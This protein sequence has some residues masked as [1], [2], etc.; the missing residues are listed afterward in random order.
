MEIKVK[1]INKLRCLKFIFIF[2]FIINACSSGVPTQTIQIVNTGMQKCSLTMEKYN[3]NGKLSDKYSIDES[4]EPQKEVFVQINEGIYMIS[5]WDAEG[6]LIKKFDKISVKLS[7]GKSSFNPIVIDAAFNKNYALVNLNYLYS[8][9]VF[10]EH[11]SK[12]VGTNSDNLEIIHFYNGEAPFFV[13]EKYR[14]SLTFVDIFTDKLPKETVYGNTVYGL[15]PV[16]SEIK[17]KKEINKYI[18]N[19]LEKKV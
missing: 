13:Q 14:T 6:K 7:S 1:Y 12:A 11:M 3:A 18:E 19:Y 16:P 10:A 2:V 15:I 8:G 17:N 5:V 4:I 9:G